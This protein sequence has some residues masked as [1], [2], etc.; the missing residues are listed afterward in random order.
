MLTGLLLGAGCGMLV[1]TVALVWLGHAGV[2]LC[3][4]AGILGGVTGA[5]VLGFSVPLLL[6]LLQR[7]PQVAAGPIALALADL[8]TLLLYFNLARWWLVA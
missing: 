2:A 7:D 1:G 6:Y 8:L 5:A 3:L 4:T